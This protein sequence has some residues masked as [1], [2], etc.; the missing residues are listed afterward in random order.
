MCLY[1]KKNA[2]QRIAKKDIECWK[3]LE[4]NVPA[5]DENHL[6]RTPFMFRYVV[7]GNE[8]RN[9]NP[10]IPYIDGPDLAIHEGFHTYRFKD[11]ALDVFDRNKKYFAPSRFCVVRCIIPAGTPY[12]IGTSTD[13]LS[14][15][16]EY[17]SQALRYTNEIVA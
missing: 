4:I 9:A 11:D 1:I 10:L 14:Y 2:K 12:Y 5:I 3:I 17:C 6:Y 15:N 7:L 13:F 8:Y 16:D